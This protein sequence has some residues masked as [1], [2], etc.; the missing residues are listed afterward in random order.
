MNP[1][2]Q[3]ENVKVPSDKASWFFRRLRNLRRRRR[4]WLRLQLITLQRPCTGEAT[5]GAPAVSLEVAV[6]NGIAAS[7]PAEQRKSAKHAIGQLMSIGYIMLYHAKPIMVNVNN[8]TCVQTVCISSNILWQI[9]QFSTLIHI[10]IVALLD[11]LFLHLFTCF[12]F[13]KKLSVSLKHA[14]GSCCWPHHA[15]C[16]SWKFGFPA[17]LGR[18]LKLPVSDN[19]NAS[20]FQ[21]AVKRHRFMILYIYMISRPEDPE[22][23]SFILLRYLWCKWA[24]KRD[25]YGLCAGLSFQLISNRVK[26]G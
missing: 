24:A 16:A 6:P 10:S 20:Y 12:S 5:E 11:K 9:R 1:S 17:Q 4:C 8:Q 19:M 26:M 7:S 14:T 2:S 23:A 15:L 18:S 21:A 13:A 25:H 22:S 3:G